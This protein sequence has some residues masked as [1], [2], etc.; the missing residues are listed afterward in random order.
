M[1]AGNTKD[2]TTVLDKINEIKVKYGI[3]KI[4]FVGDRGMVTQ[5]NYEAINHE[6]VKVISALTHGSIKK[7]REKDVIQLSLFDDKNTIEVIDGGLRYCLCKNPD[8][9]AKEKSTRTALLKKTTEELDRII[10]CTRKTKYSKEMRAGQLVNK[11]KMGKFVS[12]EGS[13]DSL[14]YTLDKVKIEQES[15][16]D[17]CYVIYTD[18]SAEDMTA[19]ETVENYKNLMQVEQAFRNMKTVRLEIRPVYHR[20]DDRIKCHVFICMLAYY[21]MWHMKQ[22]LQPFFE[23]DANA[24]D[25]KF[26]FDYAMESLKSIRK[27]TIEIC[28]TVSHSVTAPTVEQKRILQLLGVTM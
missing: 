27:Q 8:M 5:V 6:T 7:L 25:R 12:F 13:G 14:K 21:V 20:T 4:V 28:E 18:V 9:A 23:S 11:Y 15:S 19:V 24:K 1:L 16:L 3:E 22:T 26:T 2:E 10:A 17:G